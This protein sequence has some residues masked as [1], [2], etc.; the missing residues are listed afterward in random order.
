MPMGLGF[1]RTTNPRRR[2]NPS[3]PIRVRRRKTN[4]GRPKR[5]RPRRNQKRSGIV[6]PAARPDAWSDQAFHLRKFDRDDAF[7]FRGLKRT[8]RILIAPAPASSGYWMAR[9]RA[10]EISD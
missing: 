1:G 2:T 4:L 6:R 9:F 7:V 5:V 3:K 8:P 10:C